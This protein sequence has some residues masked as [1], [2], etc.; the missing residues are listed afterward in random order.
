MG[1]LFDVVREAQG[2]VAGVEEDSFVPVLN[3]GE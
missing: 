3:K 2:I 1:E